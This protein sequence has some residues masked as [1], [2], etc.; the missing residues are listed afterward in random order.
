MSD[1]RHD[2]PEGWTWAPLGDVCAINPRHERGVVGDDTPISFV[3][4]AAVDHQAGAICGGTA[5]PYGE[6]RK[7]FTHFAEGDVLFARI[8][9]CMENG[10]AAVA[11]G[12][13]NGL[14][15]GTT[16][17]HVLRPL[18]GILPDY[19]HRYLRQETI[20]RAAAANMSGTAGQLR[21]PTDYMK[22]VEL[23]VAPLAEQRRIV[24][25]IEALFEQSRS[26]RQALDRIPP[27]LKKF[28]QVVLAAAFRGDL[29]RDWRAQHSDIEPA[30]FLVEAL[31]KSHAAHS[32][33]GRRTNAAP[34]SEGVHILRESDFPDSWVLSELAEL[35]EPT[36]PITYGILKPG[37]DIP[38]GIP[39]I[40]VADIA[41]DRVVTDKVKRTS[42]EID[43]AYK[44]SRLQAGDVL[45]SIR[46]TVGRVCRVP[47]ELDGAN[48]TQDTARISVDPRVS[49]DYVVACLRSPLAQKI[50]SAA[51]R[52]VAVRGINIGDVRALQ[53]PLPPLVEQEQITARIKELFSRADAIQAAVEAAQRRADKVDQSILARA[54][55]GE[56]VP[57]DPNDEPASVLL[58]RVHLE[59][60]RI[61]HERRDKA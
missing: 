48:V 47:L 6:V 22:S 54:F 61:T 10:K 27:L 56:L 34:P 37:P 20:R 7:G 1:E 11:R 50:M 46:G 26:A 24:A 30:N 44:R 60:S 15:C 9:P 32:A 35:C 14:G 53:I 8:T 33:R 28:R 57:Q 55:R 59:K 16:E 45:L 3:P 40:R 21:V 42:K 29:T 38:D 41:G 4:M 2:L 13:V 51:I 25:K 5:R 18:G 31:R 23:P 17:F 39:Y 43:G 12:L 19:I 36:R 58:D 52:G 49:A